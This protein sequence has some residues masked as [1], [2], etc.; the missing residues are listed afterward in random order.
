MKDGESDMRDAE[1]EAINRLRR[2]LSDGEDLE[3][4]EF[5]NHL[6]HLRYHDVIRSYLASWLEIPEDVIIERSDVAY[7]AVQASKRNVSPGLTLSRVTP[8]GSIYQQFFHAP[9]WDEHSLVYSLAGPIH[10]FM[11]RY[12]LEQQGSGPIGINMDLGPVTAVAIDELIGAVRLFLTEQEPYYLLH[13]AREEY[14]RHVSQVTGIGM[15]VMDAA[16]RFNEFYDLVYQDL[17]YVP[18]DMMNAFHLMGF[19]YGT[20]MEEGHENMAIDCIRSFAFRDQLFDQITSEGTSAEAA[21][22]TKELAFEVWSN[23]AL[24]GAPEEIERYF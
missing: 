3:A 18:E 9:W 5:Y 24:N 22:A 16:T 7:I 10:L 21:T 12:L 13:E 19:Y 15:E 4:L 2:Y 14:K 23:W 6:G 1:N 17:L 8:G 20:D 11:F